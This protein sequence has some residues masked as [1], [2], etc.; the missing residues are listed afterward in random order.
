[1]F[2]SL[3]E[4]QKIRFFF[5]KR[6]FYSSLS[7]AN[8]C[9][10]ATI[11]LDPAF[12]SGRRGL[13]LSELADGRVFHAARIL[14]GQRV[15]GLVDAARTVPPPRSPVDGAVASAVGTATLDGA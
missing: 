8:L 1:M 5:F 12:E 13:Y 14:N 7:Q 9:S 4:C 15:D 11:N 3:S 10:E 6:T 2:L